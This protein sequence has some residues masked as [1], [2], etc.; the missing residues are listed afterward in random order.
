MFLSKPPCSFSSFRKMLVS[1]FQ[2]FKERIK[3]CYFT[4]LGGIWAPQNLQRTGCCFLSEGTTWERLHLGHTRLRPMMVPIIAEINKG[5]IFT[6][7]FYLS[8]YFLYS[9][10]KE[11]GYCLS[12]NAISL[13]CFPVN[14]SI[15]GT[16]FILQL[17]WK[18][19]RPKGWMDARLQV[20]IKTFLIL[21]RCLFSVSISSYADDPS[22]S[23]AS[24]M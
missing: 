16:L 7:L 6:P 3:S 19:C 9:P 13:R 10:A 17:F 8:C 23:P 4:I 2:I 22:K 20:L 11:A 1:I 14:V 18:T 5:V 15:P 24:F 12:S 21:Q